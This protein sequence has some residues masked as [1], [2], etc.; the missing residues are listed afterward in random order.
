MSVV[1]AACFEVYLNDL[2][3]GVYENFHLMSFAHNR[4]TI[5]NVRTFINHASLSSQQW[6]VR[7]STLLE[8]STDGIGSAAREGV[9]FFKMTNQ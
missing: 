8:G 6:N 4:N 7:F 9:E 1:H 3:G 2:K 5:E